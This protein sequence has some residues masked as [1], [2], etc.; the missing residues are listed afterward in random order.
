MSESVATALGESIGR[1]A[2]QALVAKAA[3]V[4][5]REGRSFRDVLADSPEV[6]RALGAAGL[7][8]ALDPRRYLGV[9]DELIERAL[10]QHRRV[11]ERA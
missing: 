11:V 4:A 5:A 1:P 3:D 7:D 2:A 9:T 10:A 6:G 8:A